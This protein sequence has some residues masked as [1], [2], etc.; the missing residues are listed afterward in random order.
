MIMGSDELKTVTITLVT[1][2]NLIAFQN[3]W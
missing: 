1:N 3:K 2:S